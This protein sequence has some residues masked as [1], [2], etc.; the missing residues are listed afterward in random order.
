MRAPS[1]TTASSSHTVL[2]L[3]AAF[4]ADDQS[5]G[6]DKF[7]LAAKSQAKQLQDDCWWPHWVCD[8]CLQAIEA[9]RTARG[10]HYAAKVNRAR[11]YVATGAHPVDL[12][13]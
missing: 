12:T 4:L 5:A 9:T 8:D 6:S 11:W 3:I 13:E 1:A 7:I 10:E 2:S